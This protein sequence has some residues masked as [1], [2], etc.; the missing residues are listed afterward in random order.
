M[1]ID[2][3][4]RH[5]NNIRYCACYIELDLTTHFTYIDVVLHYDVK[6]NAYDIIGDVDPNSLTV[7][8]M[9][10]AIYPCRDGATPAGTVLIQ[11]TPGTSKVVNLAI[12]SSTSG[13]I[14]VEPDD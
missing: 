3:T 10:K 1:H 8:A 5:T 12:V 11:L 7:L 13:A 4:D 9:K 2:S 6:I 14:V